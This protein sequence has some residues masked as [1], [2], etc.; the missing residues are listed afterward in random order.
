LLGDLS[1]FLQL[2]WNF[3]LVT[4][5][6]FWHKLTPLEQFVTEKHLEQLE[7]EQLY[8]LLSNVLL[9]RMQLLKQLSNKLSNLTLR[10]SLPSSL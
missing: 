2:D 3:Y 9:S 1:S 7:M 6:P 4:L 10:L 5:V 8:R